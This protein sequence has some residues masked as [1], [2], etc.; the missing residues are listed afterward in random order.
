ML[1]GGFECQ[2]RR[3]GPLDVEGEGHMGRVDSFSLFTGE[4]GGTVEEEE[5][6]RVGSRPVWAYVNV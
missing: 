6:V 1:S 2:K 3:E 4:K 5:L